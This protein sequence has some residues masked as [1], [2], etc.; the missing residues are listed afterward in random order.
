MQILHLFS[1]NSTL[2]AA[3]EPKTIKRSLTRTMSRYHPDRT[4]KLSLEERVEAEEIYKVLVEARH[5][6]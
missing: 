6:L 3:A 1:K 2:T 5:C 4:M